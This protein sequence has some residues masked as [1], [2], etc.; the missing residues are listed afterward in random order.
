MQGAQKPPRMSIVTGMVQSI[1]NSVSTFVE[2][3][4]PPCGQCGNNACFDNISNGIAAQI[5]FLWYAIFDGISTKV[6]RLLNL[7]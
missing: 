1:F 6:Q 2:D 3:G 7:N 5:T 4:L